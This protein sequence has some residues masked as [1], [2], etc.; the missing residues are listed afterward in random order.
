MTLKFTA[1]L[2][3]EVD[4]PQGPQGHG[5]QGPTRGQGPHRAKMDRDKIPQEKA[6]GQSTGEHQG[7]LQGSLRMHIIP[8]KEPRGTR[9][10]G[11]SWEVLLQHPLPRRHY[12]SRLP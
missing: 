12:D 10:P 4:L 6:P 2:S 7:P 5:G 3:L 11:F 1:L 9:G 8:H